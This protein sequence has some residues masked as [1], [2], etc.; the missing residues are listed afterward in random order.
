MTSNVIPGP[1]P[2]P[3]PAP[4]WL[5][6]LLQNS[7]LHLCTILHL[8]P[9]SWLIHQALHV[10]PGKPGAPLADRTPTYLQTTGDFQ[11]RLS[12]GCFEHN[13]GPVCR[14]SF[15][16]RLTHPYFQFISFLFSKNYWCRFSSHDLS[17]HLT[18]LL[19]N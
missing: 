9:T 16:G 13:T 1:V 19:C 4:V 10:L 8:R 14:A 3:L 12:R 6:Q 5:I 15:H 7:S 11:R 17:I 18:A 2:I